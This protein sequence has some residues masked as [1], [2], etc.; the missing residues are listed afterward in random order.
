M[1]DAIIAKPE[2]YGASS[3]TFSRIAFH[4]WNAMD[5]PLVKAKLICRS[6]NIQHLQFSVICYTQAGQTPSQV[7]V[8]S[9]REV[10]AC[11]HKSQE[12]SHK[13]LWKHVGMS[14]AS[15]IQGERQAWISTFWMV[16]VNDVYLGQSVI[17][18]F[19]FVKFS[20]SES[21]YFC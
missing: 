4:D 17:F 21:I 3:D 7:L 6:L 5:W 20:F 16:H 2:K 13:Y 1:T 9:A 15:E 12:F 18:L 14:A 11:V 10:C 19:V 8:N